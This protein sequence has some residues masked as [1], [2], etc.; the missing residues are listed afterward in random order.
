MDNIRNF[1]GGV[2]LVVD[3]SM[4]HSQILEKLEQV[5]TQQISAVQVWDNFRSIKKVDDL[6][7]DICQLCH[8]FKIPV[9]I[10]NNWEKLIKLPLNGIHLDAIPKNLPEIRSKINRN[11]ICGITCNNDL[12]V[13]KWA[14]EMNLDYI[15]F[16]SVFPSST[17]NSCELV[18]FETI[19]KA[20]KIFSMPIFL[21]GGIRPENLIK[22]ADLPYN[23]IAV[24]SGIMNEEKPGQALKVYLEQLNYHKNEISNHK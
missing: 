3:P 24:I 23:G 2:Y 22:L 13:V 7:R 17:S 10:N 12:E 16:C 5:V 8:N 1:S 21:A 14:D 11:F 20:R 18:E 6:I 15:S 19:K 9:L 4:G